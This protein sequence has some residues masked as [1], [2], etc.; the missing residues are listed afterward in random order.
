MYLGALLTC[1]VRVLVGLGVLIVSAIFLLVLGVVFS[2]LPAYVSFDL[3]EKLLRSLRVLRM[4]GRSRIHTAG[5]EKEGREFW[6]PS[7][8]Q[9][10][11][12]KT[13]SI[14]PEGKRNHLSPNVPLAPLAITS[15]QWHE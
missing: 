10:N 12:G 4:A 8:S 6:L 1:R 7:T 14:L 2:W 15:V 11:K 13:V 5:V 3:C 9:T